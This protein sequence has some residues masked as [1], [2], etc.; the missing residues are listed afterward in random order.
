MLKNIVPE[1][2]LAA[3]VK[4]VRKAAG[5]SKTDVARELGVSKPSVT[6]A[7]EQP[8]SSLTKLRIRIIEKYSP[9][10]VVGPVYVLKRK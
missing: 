1:K 2:E 3:V 8:D 4:R 10:K 7:E 9:F 6:N 5:K